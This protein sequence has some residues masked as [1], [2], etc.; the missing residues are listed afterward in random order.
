MQNPPCNFIQNPEGHHKYVYIYKYIYIF[1]YIHIIYIYIYNK[2]NIIWQPPWLGL[3]KWQFQ[4]VIFWKF[5]FWMLYLNN[6]KI[7]QKGPV[8]HRYLFDM[9]KTPDQNN[10]MS[11][12]FLGIYIWQ[13]II[14]PFYRK[15][16]LP[17]PSF[18]ECVSQ[19]LL[20]IPGNT[21]I[22]KRKTTH[23]Q[24]MYLIYI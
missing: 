21:A 23:E 14:S 2:I 19:F 7:D 11:G 4:K 12:T 18:R 15:T 8:K 16:T 17:K 9:L 5:Q 22:F 20:V 24:T 13:E 6:L 10:C 1:K 3:M